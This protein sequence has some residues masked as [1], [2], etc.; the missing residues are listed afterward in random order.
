MEQIQA[1]ID[2]MI[3]EAL[4]N[5]VPA[6]QATRIELER[7][8]ADLQQFRS[9]AVCNDCGSYDVRAPESK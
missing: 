8:I 3:R 2:R 6:M 9:H 7:A 5:E 1:L 4:C